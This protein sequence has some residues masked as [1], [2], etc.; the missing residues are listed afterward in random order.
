MSE[1]S[2]RAA[3]R[4]FGIKRER[5]IVIPNPLDDTFQPRSHEE[6]EECRL[7]FNLP[8]QFWLYVAHPYPH[9]NHARL[10]VAYK[11]F[12]EVSSVEWPLVLRGDSSRGKQNLDILA[13]DLGIANSVVWLPSL[14]SEDMARLYSAATAMIFP[15]LYEGCGIPV[16]EAMAC[17]CPVAASDIDAMLEFAGNAALKFDATKTDA[18]V[19]A[20][21]QFATQP[22][23]RQS[24]SSKGLIK[25][26]AY[27]APKIAANLLTAYRR[28]SSHCN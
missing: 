8:P 6:V 23:L 14:S 26:D 9:K 11:K 18:I 15:S 27:S 13:H 2:A 20:M 19:D 22:L 16:L 21:Q 7:R 10:F 4:L 17:G 3:V 5:V 12:R 1:V 24:C 28:A 25:A